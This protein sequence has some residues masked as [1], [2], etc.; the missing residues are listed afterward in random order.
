MKRRI[1]GDK[2]LSLSAILMSFSTFIVL[3]YQARLNQEKNDLILK[4]QKAS[5]T[6]CLQFR[7]SYSSIL[8]DSP[9]L[10]FTVENKG[11]GPAFI[12]NAFLLDKEEKMDINQ[13]LLNYLLD[14][15]L[16]QGIDSAN[17]NLNFS[18]IGKSTIVSPGEIVNIFGIENEA[19]SNCGSIIKDWMIDINSSPQI[20]CYIRYASIYGEQWKSTWAKE[21]HR[22][23][24]SDSIAYYEKQNL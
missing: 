4:G 23:I 17:I 10:S 7:L 11:L 24:P 6:P 9:E 18:F 5:A 1:S 13:E 2:I 20:N 14:K 16:E 3:I 12:Q 21:Y 22:K 19:C 8:R 15:L